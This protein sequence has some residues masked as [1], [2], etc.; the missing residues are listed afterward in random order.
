MKK[1]FL[2]IVAIFFTVSMGT[3]NA[4]TT[5]IGI[6]DTL[7]LEKIASFGADV[8]G[9]EIGD[10]TLDAYTTTEDIIVGT[11]SYKGSVANN[12]NWQ[13]W[14]TTDGVAGFD[15]TFADPYVTPLIPGMICSLTGSSEFTLT[16][17]L[18]GSNANASGIYPLDE[19]Q[20]FEKPIT[21]GIIY[22][23]CNVPIPA[24][25]LLLVPGLL[26]LVGFRRKNR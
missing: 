3:A 19:W 23:Y 21:D 12:N 5:Y 7:N 18:L 17:F 9:V 14:T 15:F 25:V 22:T 10:L 8:E 11:D 20:I 24:T 16:N 13:I 2:I 4:Y 1:A 6:D 26:G